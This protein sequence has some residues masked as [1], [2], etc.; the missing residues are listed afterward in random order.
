M[1]TTVDSII[2]EIEA[3]AGRFQRDMAAAAAATERATGRI[4]RA[5]SNIS[6]RTSA[7][8]SVART[9]ALGFVASIGVGTFTRLASEGLTYASSIGTISQ[10]LGVSARA[11]QEYRYAA[12]QVG[13]ETG[14]IDDALRELTLS[15]GEAADGSRTKAEAFAR[16]G[17]DLRDA[18]G[19]VIDAGDALPLI[20]QGLERIETPAERAAVLVAALGEE[21]QRLAPLLAR[22]ATG[23]NNLRDAAHRMGVV[24]S[25]RQIQQADQAADKLAE[26][27]AVLEARIAGVVSENA[28]GIS[29]LANALTDVATEAVRAAAAFGRFLRE[30][31]QGNNAVT[32]ARA[33]VM[34]RPG[35]SD[36]DL[37]SRRNRA[38]FEAGR[39]ERQRQGYRPAV[40]ILGG[41]V[42]IN[43]QDERRNQSRTQLGGGPAGSRRSRNLIDDLGDRSLNAATVEPVSQALAIAAGVPNDA[44]R[45]A[46]SMSSIAAEIAAIEADIAL[47]QAGDNPERIADA[48]RMRVDAELAAA[49]VAIAQRDDLTADQ[50]RSLISLANRRAAAERVEIAAEAT[51]QASEVE[52]RRRENSARM[53][54]DGLRDQAETLASDAELA[55]GRAARL[56]TERSILAVEQ[57]IERRRLD[58]LIAAGQI[59]DVATARANLARRQENERAV[60]ERDGASPGRRFVADL[61]DQAAGLNDRLEQLAVDNLRGLNA[62]IASALANFDDLGDVAERALK[63]IVAGL[64]EIAIQ[65]AILQPLASSLFG[66]G[67]KGGKGGGGFLGALGSIA[68]LF[69]GGSTPGFGIP[70]KAVGG[71]IQPGQLYRVGE[72]GPEYITSARPAFVTPNTAISKLASPAMS[73]AGG[74]VRIVIEEAPG[75]ASTVR[76]EATGV[77]IEVVRASAGPISDLGAQKALAAAA[78]PTLG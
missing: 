9:A 41:L 20:A 4:D 51:A 13:L 27:R 21:G 70:G 24:L 59:A 30:A 23:I 57:E 36:S 52:A 74:T 32:T 48:R 22:G 12:T 6:Q 76:T 15:L 64:I 34:R 69:G 66:G 73:G 37:A 28:D 56:E 77:A 40:S 44:R 50:R 8:F 7:A 67:T 35:E 2:I 39:R 1:A 49:N 61:A 33:E 18:T 63:R 75:F 42:T 11:L 71:S 43:R 68:G 5:V 3:R 65:Q 29:D 16:L 58:E 78:R 72:N 55:V 46:G 38:G 31:R 60:F 47:A 62:E 19:A 17:V 53:A 25:D 26:V 10:Q 54:E 45:I 14:E